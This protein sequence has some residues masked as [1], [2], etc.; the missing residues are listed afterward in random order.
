MFF[1][2]LSLDRFLEDAT[3]WLDLT[4]KILWDLVYVNRYYGAQSKEMFSTS[5]ELRTRTQAPKYSFRTYC[6]LEL[7]IIN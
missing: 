3:V 7:H 6:H 1:L 4:A 2:V 5:T